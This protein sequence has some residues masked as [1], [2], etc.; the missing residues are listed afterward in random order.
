MLVNPP[1][2]LWTL[3]FPIHSLVNLGTTAHLTLGYSI[4]TSIDTQ[5]MLCHPHHV[6]HLLSIATT[7]RR[8]VSTRQIGASSARVTKT[9]TTTTPIDATG[10]SALSTMIHRSFLGWFPEL[11]ALFAIIQISN[12]VKSAL[13]RRNLGRIFAYPAPPTSDLAIVHFSS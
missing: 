7:S 6:V 3:V 8:P 1:L 10:E 13:S 9:D 12:L 4:T 5:Y 2:G 11:L